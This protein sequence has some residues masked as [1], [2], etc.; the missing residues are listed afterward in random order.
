MKHVILKLLMPMLML[1]FTS[2]VVLAE[3]VDIDLT[4]MNSDGLDQLIED[5]D[6]AVS[7]YHTPDDAGKKL[8]L[9][10]TQENVESYFRN[11]DIVVSWAWIN[12]TYTRSWNLYTVNTHIDYKD[13]KDKNVKSDVYSE[14][15]ND[16]NGFTVYYLKVGNDVILDLRKDL[17]EELWLDEPNDVINETTGFNLS[18][19]DKDALIELKS[20]AK[21]ERIRSHVPE[22]TISDTVLS[23]TKQEV[24]SYLN[25]SE[26]EL[27]WPWFDY[28]YTRQW[29]FYTLKTSVDYKDGGNSYYGVKVY[30]EA[31]PVP[32]QYVLCYLTVD[33]NVVVDK[34]ESYPASFIPG[35][36]NSS[37][38]MIS[39]SP[40]MTQSEKEKQSDVE[41]TLE[42]PQELEIAPVVLLEKGAKGDDVKD[43]QNKLIELGYLDGAADGDFGN[44]TKAAVE[45]FQSR[46]SMDVT[47]VIT[48]DDVEM[49]NN[50]LESQRASQVKI[51]AEEAA[52]RK[53]WI[54]DQFHWWSGAH[55]DLE[56]LIKNKLNDEGS[57]EHIETI[58]IDVADETR[59]AAVDETL[60]DL[61]YSKR[62]KI[63]DLFIMTE[64]SAKNAF[65]AR[66]K[67]TALGVASYTENTVTLI[68]IE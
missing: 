60:R 2:T 30:A 18:P 64:F 37:R 57:Y 49:L 51:A 32:D 46:N 43:L 61:G 48:N 66:I 45:K 1:I 25:K 19:M 59:K 55:K 39:D 6:K 17:P 56:K 10:A 8:A 36:N 26:R 22:S 23:L 50:L 47:G 15:F 24:A 33:E 54:N 14:V 3:P 41:P 63:G 65:N 11:Q 29:D 13:K 34:R 35:L 40:D 4:V 21:D 28:T 52:A 16:G 68:G 31:Y 5:V 20:M 7:L 38:E 67:H 58:H 62:V 53:K 44:K 42:L 27:S 9:A 12:Y